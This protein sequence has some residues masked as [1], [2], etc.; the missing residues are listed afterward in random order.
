MGQKNPN[1]SLEIF[2]AAMCEAWHNARRNLVLPFGDG[3]DAG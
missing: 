1:I 3:G 2:G